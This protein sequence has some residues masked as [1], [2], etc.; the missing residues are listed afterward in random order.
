[1]LFSHYPALNKRP[2]ITFSTL[3]QAFDRVDDFIELKKEMHRQPVEKEEDAEFLAELKSNTE[4]I[5]KMRNCVAH[6]RR[7][8]KRIVENYTNAKVQLHDFLDDFLTRMIVSEP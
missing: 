4:S 2:Q 3:L 1:M 6:Y 7:P 8:S 5:E